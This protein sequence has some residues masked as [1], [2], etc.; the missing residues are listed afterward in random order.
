MEQLDQ[1]ITLQLQRIDSNLSWCFGKITREIIPCVEEYGVTCDELAD[2]VSYLGGLFQGTGF[3]NLPEKQ[4][5]GEKTEETEEAEEQQHTGPLEQQQQQ[6]SRPPFESSSPPTG[7]SDETNDST[8]QRRKRKVSLLLQQEYG[9][10]SS[11]DATPEQ[12]STMAGTVIHFSTGRG[13]RSE[14][15]PPSLPSDDS[16]SA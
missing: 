8:R 4:E 11:S 13:G 15:S 7:L 6:P 12:T 2:S 1:E 3:V 14:P 10:S 16:S 9:S 5:R